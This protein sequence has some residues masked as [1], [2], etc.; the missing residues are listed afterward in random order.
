MQV[1]LWWFSQVLIKHSPL[2]FCHK[3][4]LHFLKQKKGWLNAINFSSMHQAVFCIFFLPGAL[5]LQRHFFPSTKTKTNYCHTNT[6][7]TLSEKETVQVTS[8]EQSL[9][10]WRIP[11]AG[12]LLF[13]TS[14]SPQWYWNETQ[15]ITTVWWRQTEKCCVSGKKK[16][17]CPFAP[18]LKI[19]T[20]PPSH[21]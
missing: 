7:N 3:A 4:D 1:L 13:N 2:F 9:V 5:D 20:P 6:I 11:L 15:Q 14:V 21:R 18:M 8:N 12:R 19:I 10:I 17:N 16:E